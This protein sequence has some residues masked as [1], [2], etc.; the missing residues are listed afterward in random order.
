MRLRFWKAAAALAPCAALGAAATAGE[1]APEQAPADRS[2][3]EFL[4][5]EPDLEAELSEALMTDRLDEEIERS[6]G[7]KSEVN[8]DVGKKD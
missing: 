5:E 8:E 3:F 1:Q 2:F 4:A 7:R 6:G